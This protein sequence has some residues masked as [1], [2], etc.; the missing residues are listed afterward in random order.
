MRCVFCQDVAQIEEK[1]TYRR[2]TLSTKSEVTSKEGE[3]YLKANASGTAPQSHARKGSSC[4]EVGDKNVMGEG[5]GV[6]SASFAGVSRCNYEFEILMRNLG[7]L[8]V[9]KKKSR[10]TPL[11]IDQEPKGRKLSDRAGELRMEM[12]D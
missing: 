3:G 11:L 4:N 6:F 7:G 5:K 10:R 9:L 12:Q 8:H 1:H 2:D